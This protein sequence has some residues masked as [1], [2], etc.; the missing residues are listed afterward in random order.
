MYI[1]AFAYQHHPSRVLVTGKVKTKTEVFVQ[2]TTLATT[3]I[4]G[5][6]CSLVLVPYF[7]YL[8][9]VKPCMYVQCNSSSTCMCSQRMISILPKI[10]AGQLAGAR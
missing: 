1:Y 6:F 8:D 3:R 5:F 4:Y 7:F 9:D 2:L 10:L